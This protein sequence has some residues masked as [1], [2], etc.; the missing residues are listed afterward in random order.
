MGYTVKIREIGS[1]SA[2]LRRMANN[3]INEEIETLINLSKQFVWEGTTKTEFM[4]AFDKHIQ[5]LYLTKNMIDG[6][7]KVLSMVCEEFG[8]S[9]KKIGKSWEETK[10]NLKTK[11]AQK[12]ADDF[13]ESHF[14]FTI[15]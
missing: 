15:S 12:M 6:Y 5:N 10:N 3:K 7:G 2:E 9:F 1:T 14:N 8:G 4:N 11:T 13:T